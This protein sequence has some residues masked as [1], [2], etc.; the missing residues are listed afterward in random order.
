MFAIL[1]IIPLFLALL[2]MTAFKVSSSRSL[3]IS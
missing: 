2:L 1:A 3:L